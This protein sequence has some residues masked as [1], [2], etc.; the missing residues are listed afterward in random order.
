MKRRDL[1]DLLIAAGV[2]VI[3]IAVVAPMV[4]S[5]SS[6]KASAG[7]STATTAEVP[8]TTSP[9]SVPGTDVTGSTAVTGSTDATGS[10]VAG[11]VGGTTDEGCKITERSIRQGS[12]GQSVSCLQTALAAAGYYSGPATGNYDYATSTAVRKLQTEKNLFVDGVAGRET[13]LA[14]GIW[15]D[16]ASLVVHTPPPAPGATDTLGYAL[17]SVAV[18]GPDA[19]PVPENSGTGRRLVYSRTGQRVWA[20]GDDGQVIR[21]WLVSGSKFENEKPGTY[22]V[23]SRSE[24]TTAWNGKAYLK[25]MVRYLK[26][27]IGAIGFHQIPIHVADG[28]VYQTEAELGQRL[29]GGCQRQ[30]TLDADFTWAWAQVGTVVVV[31]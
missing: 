19:P 14:L 16:E 22:K 25:H 31:L 28:T 23:Y 4:G 26:T 21:S 17:S 18:S 8:A 11:D 3:G 9:P 13:G 30:A 10:T 12:T 29:S 27:K 1:R 24:I 15:P 6:S 7:N 5:S 2:G 20:I